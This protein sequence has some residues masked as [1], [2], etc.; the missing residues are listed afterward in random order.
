MWARNKHSASVFFIA[1]LL[2]GSSSGFSQTM[3]VLNLPKYEFEKLHF[4]FTLGINTAN[5][6]IAPKQLKDS[7]L[8]VRSSPQS[9]FNLGIVSEYAIQRYL[10]IRFLPD[11]SFAERELDYTVDT[12]NY[13][14]GVLTKTIQSTFLDFPIDLKLRSARMKNFAAYVVAGGKYTLDLASQGD[15]NNADLSAAQQVVKL[16]RNDIGYEMGAGTEFYLPYF[17]F[18]IEAKLSLGFK[19]L[20]ISDNTIFANAIDHLYSKMF[21]LSFT[22]EG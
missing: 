20:L 2:T 3:G 21:L 14:V 6:V 8:I 7:I 9:G 15:V 22:F 4:G 13:G 16:T 17:K 18:G 12:K 19:N 5:F 10:T 1:L 11:I